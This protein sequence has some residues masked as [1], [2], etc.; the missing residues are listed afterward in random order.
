MTNSS[1]IPSVWQVPEEFRRRLG[2]TA[3][4]QRLMQSEGH[5]LLV[6]HEVPQPDV[7]ARKGALFWR[8]AAGQWR[9]S[10]G[11]A[12]SAALEKHLQRYAQRL[13]DFDQLEQAAQRA[14]Q[15]SQ[16]L[17]GL[18]PIARAVRNMLD[19]LEEARKAK[20]EDRSLIDL[21]DRGYELARWAELLYDDAKNAMDVA[22]VKRAEEQAAASHRMLVSA[23]RLNLL[24]ALFFPF[25]TLGAIFGTTLTDNWSWSR[26]VQAFAAFL[27]VGLISGL[28][29]AAFIS[30]EPPE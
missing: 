9:G 28:M 29:L 1:L 22:V 2:S 16:L 3:G 17:E 14:D 27:I 20:P 10:N 24:A 4:R 11:E 30:R 8:D 18:A 19:V 21:R 15:Y 7:V 6:L 23:H 5:L 25:G 12:G 26:S 13:E